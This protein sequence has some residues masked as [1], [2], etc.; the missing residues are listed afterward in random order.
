MVGSESIFSDAWYRVFSLK[1]R[2]AQQL[3]IVR[4]PVRNQIWHVLTEAASGRQVRLN[5]VAWEFCG[6]CD[7]TYAVGEL[8]QF[9]LAR[10]GEDAPTQ[11]D[12]LRILSQLYRNGMVQFDAAPHLSMLFAQRVRVGKAD[13][14]R[15]INPLLLRMRLF[16]PGAMLD[17]IEPWLRPVFSRTGLLMWG[18]L[19]TMGFALCLVNFS[20]LQNETVAR[21]GSPRLLLL[22]WLSYP[23]IKAVHE[24]GHAV[25]VRHFG[26]EV[27]EMGLTLMLLTPAPYV[28]ASAANLFESRSHRVA[29][30]AAGIMVEL[31]I[32]ALAV[33][34]WLIV[35]PGV[36][37]DLALVVL[38]I[39]SVSTLLINGNP[40]LKLDGYYVMSD[41]L[42]LPNLAARSNAW[43]TAM[44]YKLARGQQQVSEAT[45]AAG[46]LKWLALYAPASWMFRF[47]LLF[48]LV[49]WVGS[50]SATL[51][52]GMGLGLLGWMAV[53]G[54]AFLLQLSGMAV[55]RRTRVLAL[56]AIT[57]GVIGL[58]LFAL[59][60]PS[61][62]VARG[63]VW[64]PE[65]AQ[66]RP[67]VS[68]IVAGVAAAN[69][70][71]VMPGEILMTL[72]DPSLSAEHE[73]KISQLA[74]LQAQQYLSL[75]QNPVK[76][77]DIA[78]SISRIEAEI[79]RV[80]QQ[81]NQLQ[82][83]S[84]VAGRMVLSSLDDLPGSYAARGMMLGYIVGD[85]PANV[86]VVL[87][88]QNVVLVR[89]RI[90]AVEVRL[91]DFPAQVMLG[92]LDR[93]VPG[94]T[95]KLPNPV[96]G[97][98]RGGDILVDPSDKE[99]MRTL[100]PVFLVDVKVPEY[101]ASR[102]GGRAWVKFDLGYE[103]PGWQL[104]RRLRQLVLRDFN[105]VG[106][107]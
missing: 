3:K 28:D 36:I 46:E 21:M 53:K 85:G 84:Q 65:R 94:A 31:L 47:G 78:G 20:Q 62:V 63:V 73:R 7:G 71:L 89:D 76:A 86:R 93:E 104:L 11:D 88:E 91:A 24:L 37:R 56:A 92:Q 83:R 12:V 70:A 58:L 77:V 26:G 81:L 27:H 32:A 10:L 1:P 64:P 49:G 35:Q 102:I 60:L 25:T 79:E 101:S 30:S 6:R 5:P 52:W 107:S 43:W 80:E 57:F 100:A 34:V 13:R 69:G 90:K 68:G 98:R 16:D 19:V 29:V 9:L 4:Q 41:A 23:F 105:P 87:D 50:K 18:F 61:T 42:Q 66:V 99:A 103:P 40:L 51:G 22:A 48:A 72:T 39:C 17:R 2:L 14:Q 38:L 75:M 33:A 67:E 15:A 74:G 96:L 55:G 54:T 44:F 45:L 106:Q 59:P 95:R 8:W 82:V 97:D